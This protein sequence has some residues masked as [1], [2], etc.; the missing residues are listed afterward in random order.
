M[1]VSAALAGC[2]FNKGTALAVGGGGSD[3]GS[4]GSDA[5]DGAIEAKIDA[6]I[7]TPDAC[8]MHPLPPVMNVDPA[9][10]KADFLTAPTWNC[11]AAGTTTIDLASGIAPG[12]CVTT[13][14]Y[15]DNVAQSGGGPNVTVVRLQGLTVT[16]GHVLQFTGSRPVV[17]LV[18]GDVTIDSGGLIDVGASGLTNGPGGLDCM[19]QAN[20]L[21]LVSTSGGY[22]G[23]GGG[24][25]TAGGQGGYNTVNGGDAQSGITLAP[26]RGGCRGG[27][28]SSSATGVGGAGGAIE[29]SA[30]GTITIGATSA[31]GISAGGGG[32]PAALAG[33]AV[34]GNGGGSGG[35]ILLVSPVVATFGTNG[36]LFAN[37]GAG[38]SGCG[39]SCTSGSAM[40]AG[41][42]GSKTS[43]TP[44][45][46]TSGT[47]GSQ[48]NDHGRR[49]GT[50]ALV[51]TTGSSGAG[52]L[53]NAQ[54]TGGRG[55]G[56]GG[57]GVLVVTMAN[58][59]QSCD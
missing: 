22:G 9:S 36:A 16:N 13:L 47:A 24:F 31:A 41:N 26:L 27:N 45:T 51:G 52:E 3:G 50:M 43:T 32:A 42:D 12:G 15:T 5:S 40:Q 30:S 25:G 34:G 54:T 8:T 10:W 46:D 19:T 57:G 7:D 59:S 2:S 4:G 23:G 37:G 39:G 17:L 14:D 33:S 20:G 48:N 35:G 38:S 58:A 56:G 49:G 53:P 6:P 55:G 11:S 21:G 44:A 1:V 18:A 29:I 28:S